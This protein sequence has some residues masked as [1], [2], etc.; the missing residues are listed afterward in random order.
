MEI[1]PINYSLQGQCKCSILGFPILCLLPLLSLDQSFS[2][3]LSS[4]PW[5]SESCATYIWNRYGNR[6]ACSILNWCRC[7]LSPWSYLSKDCTRHR[8]LL[9]MFQEL[10]WNHYYSRMDQQ[11]VRYAHF[12]RIECYSLASLTTFMFPFGFIGNQ[13]SSAATTPCLRT[14]HK[15]T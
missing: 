10:T 11:P 2:V 7:L 15:A 4:N 12:Y 14:F 1:W 9:W 13:S 6:R 5:Y 3:H 8:K